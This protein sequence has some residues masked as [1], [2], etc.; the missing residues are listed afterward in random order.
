MYA[1][2]LYKKRTMWNLGN[3]IKKIQEKTRKHSLDKF[4]SRFLYEFTFFLIWLYPWYILQKVMLNIW[5]N[6]SGDAVNEI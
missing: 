4:S 6:E 2:I 1:L 3:N 5:C